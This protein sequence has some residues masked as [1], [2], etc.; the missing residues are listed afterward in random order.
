MKEDAA[1]AEAAALLR[2]ILVQNLAPV[3]D[4]D[5]EDDP[6]GD[7]TGQPVLELD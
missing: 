7:E 4:P 3:P 5:G 6:P 2:R 1:V